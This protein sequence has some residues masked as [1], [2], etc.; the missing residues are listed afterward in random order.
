MPDKPDEKLQKVLAR[1]GLGSRREMETWIAAGRVEVNEHTAKIGARVGAG[2]SIKVD[3][4]PVTAGAGQEKACRVLCYHKPVGEVCTRRDEKSR[5]TIFEHLPP[6]EQGRWIQVGRLDLNSS[7]LLL[8]TTDGELANKLMHPSSGI[9]REYAVRVLGEVDGLMMENLLRGVELDDGPARFG[10][11]VDAGG[12]GANHWY[13]V[14]IGEGRNREVRRL[15]ESQGV[16]VSRLLRIRFGPILLDSKLAAGGFR[17]LEPGEINELRRAAGL[18]PLR[19]GGKPREPGAVAKSGTRRRPA[20]GE[21]HK[22]PARKRGRPAGGDRKERYTGPAER[23]AGRAPSKGRGRP[24]G[25]GGRPADDAG[26]KTTARPGGR[27]AAGAGRKAPTR[28]GGKPAEGAGRRAPA[29]PGGRSA[30]GAG[31]KAP[32][33]SGGKPAEGAGRRAPARPGGKPAAGAG[34]KAPTRGGG[35]PAAGAGRK[36]PARG[37]G[38]PAGGA[39]RKAPAGQRGKPAGGAGG[40]NRGLYRGKKDG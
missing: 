5:A 10:S 33:R 14:T 23:A 36:A 2:D 15:W 29:R 3:G 4:R 22:A 16:Q 9:E 11:I 1:A 31:R 7:G 27:P 38:K 34:R 28:G 25:E 12:T 24:A 32:T 18:K 13:H 39:G 19:T 17:D 6:L 8:L 35:K 26:R 20:G 40:G 37:G 30:A 21:R